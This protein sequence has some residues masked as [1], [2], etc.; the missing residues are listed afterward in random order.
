MILFKMK[1]H[2]RISKIHFCFQKKKKG[3]G[4]TLTEQ[5]LQINWVDEDLLQRTITSNSE[6]RE[7]TVSKQYKVPE[8]T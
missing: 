6:Q 4:V 8:V 5:L 3:T 2:C 7:N 1:I